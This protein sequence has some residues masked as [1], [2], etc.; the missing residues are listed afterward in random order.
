VLRFVS[1]KSVVLA[2]TG[3]ITL[4]SGIA[5]AP[6]ASAATTAPA[7][8]ANA[9]GLR[10]DPIIDL[11]GTHAESSSTQGTATANVLQVLGAPLG[12]PGAGIDVL[13]QLGGTATGNNTK[14]GALVDTGATPLGRLAVAPWSAH[15]TS[16]PTHRHADAAAAIASLVLVNDSTLFAQILS[17]GSTADNDTRTGTSTS[18]AASDGAIVGVGGALTVD[19][20]HS[21]ASTAQGA[22]SWL[23][24]I[25]GTHLV[26]NEQVGNLCSIAL[27]G[28]LSIACLNVIGGIGQNNGASILDGS[29]LGMVTPGALQ[30]TSTSGRATT[31]DGAPKTTPAPKVSSTKAKPAPKGHAVRGAATGRLPRTGAATIALAA[32]GLVLCALGLAAVATARMRTAP[33]AV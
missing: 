22:S 3:I 7:S 11:S 31:V 21:D 25:N 9:L 26:T 19:V 5:L 1:R 17:S 4:G 2:A 20:L 33:M 14:A 12:V 16:T 6:T 28:V 10:L 24:G 8:E 30:L 23:L 13:P 18:S 29:L 27:P 32:L 15:A